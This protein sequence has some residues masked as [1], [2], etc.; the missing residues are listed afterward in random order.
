MKTQA[1]KNYF[2]E[3]PEELQ[4][5]KLLVADE[6]LNR[7]KEDLSVTLVDNNRDYRCETCDLP[8]ISE[9]RGVPSEFLLEFVNAWKEQQK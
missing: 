4:R 3:H 5:Q 6:I 9:V 1:E 7:L 8:K 2:A